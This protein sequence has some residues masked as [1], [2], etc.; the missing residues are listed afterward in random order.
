M[1]GLYAFRLKQRL[2]ANQTV[3]FDDLL[4]WFSELIFNLPISIDILIQLLA[5]IVDLLLFSLDLHLQHQHFFGEVL[6]KGLQLVVLELYGLAGEEH[7]FLVVWSVQLRRVKVGC[8][9]P[10]DA[11]VLALALA[12]LGPQLGVL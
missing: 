5:K 8:F 11:F 10:L 9:W 4:K 2:S 12:V 7:F 1:Q 6:L 3:F